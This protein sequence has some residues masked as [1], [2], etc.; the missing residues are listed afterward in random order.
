MDILN[1]VT[2]S[3]SFW[4]VVVGAG[5]IAVS[6][7]VNAVLDAV[8]DRKERRAYSAAAYRQLH[9]RQAGRRIVDANRDDTT[10]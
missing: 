10:A 4:L 5:F 3:V 6:M 9:E 2:D 8:Q 1:A 7:T